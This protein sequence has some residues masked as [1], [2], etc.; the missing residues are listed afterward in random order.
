M[1]GSLLLA[2]YSDQRWRDIKWETTSKQIYKYDNNGYCIEIIR[3]SESY[4]IGLENQYKNSFTLDDHQN[5]IESIDQKWDGSKWVNQYKN[6]YNYKDINYLTEYLIQVWDS[7][8]WV[9]YIRIVSEYDENNNRTKEFRQSWDGTNWISNQVFS[10]GYD[11][12][13]NLIEILWQV[14]DSINL[15]NQWKEIY[16]YDV[17]NNVV[18]HL[19]Q[20]WNSLIWTN[21]DRE[22]YNY[23]ERNN[24]IEKIYQN[25]KDSSWVNIAKNIYTFNQDNYKST[26]TYQNW[27]GDSV[28]VSTNRRSYEYD[29][30][31]NNIRVL[32]QGRPY[33]YDSLWI[34]FLRWENTY[35]IYNNITSF[36]SWHK[37]N[38]KNW[39]NDT[40]IIYINIP[41]NGTDGNLKNYWLANNY[42]NPFNNWTIIRFLIP[43]EEL[44]TLK[45]FNI[46]GVEVAFLLNENRQEGVYEIPWNPTTLASGVYFYQLKAGNFI[47]TKKMILLK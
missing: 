1:N 30:R 5:V 31:G 6:F 17:R 36:R 37:W 16:K 43:K 39:V 14:R 12:N 19:N 35:D 15:I 2:E 18:E 26:D 45:V 33:L 3:Q 10:Y 42:P 13:K 20:D 44:V 23:N 40:K 4:D 38:N 27:V 9:S 41:E 8:N 11:I 46:L 47:A 22:L 24:N 21:Y 34:D 32:D 7:T 28:W 29:N 25:W